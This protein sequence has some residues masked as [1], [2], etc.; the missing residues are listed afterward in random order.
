MNGWQS[1]NQD[2]NLSQL[3]EFIQKFAD[4]LQEQV[5]EMN[6][7]NRKEYLSQ[8]FTPLTKKVKERSQVL[9]QGKPNFLINRPLL[10]EQT[11]GNNSMDKAQ[12][13]IQLNG[14]SL[15]YQPQLLKQDGIT[16]V[17]GQVK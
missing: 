5:K 15:A 3:T 11:N 12:N 14:D 1:K 6:Q 16:L 10:N 7:S 4:K 17:Q 8:V 9:F 13:H 2:N